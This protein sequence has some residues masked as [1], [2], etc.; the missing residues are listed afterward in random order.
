MAI[1]LGRVSMVTSIIYSY[2][3]FSVLLSRMLLKDEALNSLMVIGS[4]L[5]VLGVVV[6]SLLG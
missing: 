4:L 1:N 5:I 6:V 3:L 2:H